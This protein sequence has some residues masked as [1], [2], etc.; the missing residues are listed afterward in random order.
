MNNSRIGRILSG[1][2]GVGAGVLCVI[3]LALP[4]MVCAAPTTT[5]QAE[6]VV[7][8]W[9]S[10]DP[11]PLETPVG[12]RIREVIPYRDADGAAAY[13]VVCLEPTGFVIVAGDD[14]VGPVVA[15]AASG[16]YDPSDDNPLGA[17]VS[18]DLA[19]R[20]AAARARKAPRGQKAQRVWRALEE[21]S[22]GSDRRLRKT[23]G[24]DNVSEVH[25]APLVKSTW[26]QGTVGGM[27]CYNY[28]TPHQY[29]CGCVATA[30]AQVMRFY[31]YPTKKVARKKHTIYV[32]KKKMKRRLQGGKYEWDKMPLDPDLSIKPRQ[33]RA[34]GA[35]CHDAG[36]ASHMRYSPG[37][38]G[39]SLGDAKT[40]LLGTFQYSNA[41]RGS[42]DTPGKQRS[43]M[44]N[45]N[46]AAGRPCIIGIYK[47]GSGH[48]VVCDGY[49]YH[50]GTLYHHL[51]MG[52]AGTGDAWYA[53][54]E[55][56]SYKTVTSILYNVFEKD[57]GEIVSGRVLDKKGKP[58]PKAKVTLK[59]S[60]RAAL[61]R[62]TD[63][64]G[65]YAFEKLDANATY[66]LRAGKE[67]YKFFMETTATGRSTSGDTSCGNRWLVNIR[68]KQKPDLVAFKAYP[69]D[70]KGKDL[71]KTITVGDVF[72]P[73]LK[74]ECQ[75]A[76]TG[77]FRLEIRHDG[78][79]RAA[80]MKAKAGRKY[81][82]SWPGGLAAKSGEHRI[83][84]EV[85]VNDDVSERKEG[86][87]W[88]SAAYTPKPKAEV[89]ATQGPQGLSHLTLS[90]MNE[91]GTLL[92]GIPIALLTEGVDGGATFITADSAAPCRCPPDVL[93]TLSAPESVTDGG[94]TLAFDHWELSGDSE[95]TGQR[96]VQLR[97]TNHPSAVAVY[98][99]V[100]ARP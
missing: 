22:Q 66:T 28:Y 8:G 32:N 79:T 61:T 94:R 65:V 37:G 87:N 57:S 11:R 9:L 7:K 83:E 67:G 93:V 90:A 5:S 44:L 58:V 26:A 80:Y 98:R 1:G 38:S 77:T 84:G 82:I 63:G 27:P 46:L 14:L 24:R 73:T 62:K 36:V 49:G 13:H 75:G 99:E 4:A 18:R 59:Q 20:T 60:G 88:I 86:N 43:R 31:S 42:S 48:A 100:G 35:L 29:P 25:V 68:Q 39:T 17:L 50:T 92:P 69:A 85:D 56:G 23:L 64:K 72:W 89:A 2:Q 95:P 21:L 41:I 16:R 45:A 33:R 40:A 10:L 53:L 78:Q 97:I 91:Q 15:L 51:N 47:P 55:V 30:M 3:L 12:H 76:D 19:A 71:T 96:S 6:A 54:P 74:F 52:W 34:I 70:S 81:R